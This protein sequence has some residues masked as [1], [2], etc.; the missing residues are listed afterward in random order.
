MKTRKRI[1]IF[2]NNVKYIIKDKLLV[3]TTQPIH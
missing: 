3:K 2:I 1:Y